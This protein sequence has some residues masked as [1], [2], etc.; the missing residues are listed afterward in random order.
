M[1]ADYLCDDAV[2]DPV[3]V[4]HHSSRKPA[5]NDG[6]A[7][8]PYVL[9]LIRRYSYG[10]FPFHGTLDDMIASINRHP[11]NKGLGPDI[12]DRCVCWHPDPRLAGCLIECK[13]DDICML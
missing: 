12:F 4:I 5:M 6:M 1:T 11:D 10:P 13:R 8:A 3:T 9:A 2:D 7:C